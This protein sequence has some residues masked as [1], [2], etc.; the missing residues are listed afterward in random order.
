MSSL[1]PLRLVKRGEYFKRKPDARS[2]YRRGEY[3]RSTKRISATDFEDMN[4]EVF[5]NPDTLVHVDFT[6]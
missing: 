5:L 3:D 1:K 4:R 2:V 6:F